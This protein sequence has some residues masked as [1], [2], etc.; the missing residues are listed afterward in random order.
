MSH[1]TKPLPKTDF[2][3]PE[4]IEFA[5]IDPKTGG[6]ATS[7]TKGAIFEAFV[8]GTAPTEVSQP[9]SDEFNLYQRDE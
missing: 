2:I 6:L 8:K 5:R 9:K 1:A 3:V 4:N 7:K